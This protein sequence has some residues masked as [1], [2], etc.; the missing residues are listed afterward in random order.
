MRGYQLGVLVGYFSNQFR[1]SIDEQYVDGIVVK[2]LKHIWTFAAGLT[3]GYILYS[4]KI[5]VL[6]THQ[7]TFSVG[8]LP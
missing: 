4:L 8:G 1:S 5:F 7:C 6:V 3:Q 2:E